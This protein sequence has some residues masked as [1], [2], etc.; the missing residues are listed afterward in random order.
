MDDA[1]RDLRVARNGLL[2]EL[3]VFGRMRYVSDPEEDFPGGD[4]QDELTAGVSLEI[5]FDKR[6]QRDGVRR[7]EIQLAAAERAFDG[8]VANVHIGII[9]NINSLHNFKR[10]VA[11]EQTNNE[12]AEKRVRNA[13]LRFQSGELSNRDVVEAE[14]ELL[15]T[16]NRLVEALLD[17]EIERLRLL[18]NMGL[19]E[20][21]E[22]GAMR[23]LPPSTEG[24]IALFAAPSNPALPESD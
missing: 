17:H 15:D 12:I 14:N 23:E 24:A 2:P 20:I 3:N 22:T 19:L 7:A 6:R 11:I 1:E 8:Q 13:V 16:R 10:S 5:P 18:R 4:F 21:D 9:D